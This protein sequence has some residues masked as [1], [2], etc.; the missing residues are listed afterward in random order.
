MLD[1]S[2]YPEQIWPMLEALDRYADTGRPLGGFLS[3]V[4]CNEFKE[5]CMRADNTNRRFLWHF[6]V[7]VCNELPSVCHGS[8]EIYSQW[9]KTGGL[10]GQRKLHGK[11]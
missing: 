11:A 10:E 3:S 6:A 2:E 1:H 8:R 7:Y 5:A 4:I 9:L